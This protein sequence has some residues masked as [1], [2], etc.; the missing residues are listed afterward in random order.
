MIDDD[1]RERYCAKAEAVGR[2]YQ[3]GEFAGL[4]GFYRVY[5]NFI[6]SLR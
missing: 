3:S 5:L 4:Y 6:I 1:V 2:G